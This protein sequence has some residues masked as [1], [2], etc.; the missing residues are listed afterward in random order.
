MANAK[1]S[2]LSAQCSTNAAAAA[3]ALAGGI[4][5]SDVVALADVLKTMS[6]RNDFAIQVMKLVPA[7]LG[8]TY[9]APG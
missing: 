2:A 5:T 9:I 3:T 4:V 8:P 1:L 7:A 6:L